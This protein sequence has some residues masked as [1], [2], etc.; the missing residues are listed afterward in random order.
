MMLSVR[1]ILNL[2]VVNKMYLMR[3]DY[4]CRLWVCE[5][6]EHIWTI[7]ILRRASV[8]NWELTFTWDKIDPDSKKAL[9]ETVSHVIQIPGEEP[10]ELIIAKAEFLIDQKIKEGNTK[11]VS[12]I[13]VRSA[14]PQ[15]FIDK[16]E[17]QA[18]EN[19]RI[20][21]SFIRYD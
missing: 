7:T 2:W 19:D 11:V 17:E 10:E 9:C 8:G 12:M 5:S 18:I 13:D 1:K 16:F 21:C 4:V 15:V 14:D 20:A 6:E 3:G